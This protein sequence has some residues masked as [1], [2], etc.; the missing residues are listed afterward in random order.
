MSISPSVLEQRPLRI[1]EP[2]PI[3]Y[4]AQDPLDRVSRRPTEV[5]KVPRPRNAFIIFRCQT[6]SKLHSKDS[7]GLDR[8]PTP[9][10]TLSKRAGVAWRQLSEEEK[11]VY[12]DLAEKERLEH[13]DKYPGYKYQPNRSKLNKTRV[14]GPPTRRER[15]ES[16]VLR[17]TSRSGTSPESGESVCPSPVSGRSSPE[18][19]AIP[20]PSSAD[21][22]THSLAHRR[23]MSLPHLVHEP[24]PF[25]RTYF[26]EPTSCLSSPGLGPH[27]TSRRSS[28]ARDRSYLPAAMTPP[29]DC[30]FDLQYP[31]TTIPFSSLAPHSSSL[32]LP[33]LVTLSEGL[34]LDDATSS[35]SRVLSAVFDIHLTL[36]F[37]DIRPRRRARLCM[38]TT[39]SSCISL[40]RHHRGPSSIVVNDRTLHRARLSRLWLQ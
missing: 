21:D 26:I 4:R 16:L 2:K 24:Y 1:S 7:A 30:A 31:H 36:I 5:N 11:Q 35:V 14:S 28:S 37:R 20:I 13:Q 29:P 23:S 38:S 27:R 22:S 32:S 33:D 25:A 12:K 8:P 18:A 39:T 15:V 17:T 9:E 19:S 3:H 10:K 34:A 6:I 40:R